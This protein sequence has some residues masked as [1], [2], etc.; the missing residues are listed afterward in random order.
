MNE[1]DKYSCSGYRDSIWRRGFRL[2]DRSPAS[3][4]LRLGGCGW[5][6]LYLPDRAHVRLARGGRQTN[7]YS[8]LI[9]SVTPPAESTRFLFRRARLHEAG[10]MSISCLRCP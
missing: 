5:R 2:A 6:W 9:L 10:D 7:L 1:S 3:V 4:D 8:G